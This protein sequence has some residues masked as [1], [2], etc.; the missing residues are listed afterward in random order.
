M[1]VVKYTGRFASVEAGQLITVAGKLAN[2]PQRFDVELTSGTNDDIQLHI[3]VRFQEGQV[4]RNT[5]RTG[6][7][8]EKEERCENIFP[9]NSLMPFKRGGEFKIEIFVDPAAFFI[10]VDEKPFCSFVHRLPIHTIQVVNV[11]RDV[12]AVYQVSRTSARK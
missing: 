6:V 7:G 4:V 1:S 12:E 5:R 8:W 2:N 3:S 11:L 9:H 10:T